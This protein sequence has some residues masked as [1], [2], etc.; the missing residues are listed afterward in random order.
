[1]GR[2]G[3]TAPEV[4]MNELRQNVSQWRDD[5]AY[6]SYRPTAGE[7]TDKIRR[8]LIFIIGASGSGTTMLT[9]ILSRPKEVIPLGGNYDEIPRSNPRAA[10]LGRVFK[11]CTKTLWDRKAG[12]EVHEEARRKLRAVVEDLFELDVFTDATSILHKR[13]APF[14]LSD[15]YRPDL[16]DLFDLFENP[17]LIVVYRDPKASTYSSLRRGFSRN[18]RQ[19]AVICEEQLT[20]LNSQIAGLDAGSYTLINYEA[21]CEQP[22]EII[23]GVAKFAGL[24]AFVLKQATRDEN[25]APGRIDRW[26]TSLGPEEV[27]YLD[28]FFS[29][30]R[31]E[32][33]SLLAAQGISRG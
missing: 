2:R 5:L 31:Q 4:P 17:R 28:H 21:F 9:R 16:L 10:F 24:E 22:I 8:R 14:L 7:G 20:Y 25:V 15:R 32:Q 33:W 3:L 27:K 19:S 30:R 6:R 18:L 23:E 11:A 13:S 1:M 12:F 29:D 26:R